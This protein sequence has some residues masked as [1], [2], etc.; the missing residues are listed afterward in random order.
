MDSVYI[1]ILM[2][3]TYLALIGPK[4]FVSTGNFCGAESL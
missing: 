2:G 1:G 4:T 3:C